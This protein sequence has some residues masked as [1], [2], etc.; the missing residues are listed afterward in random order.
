MSKAVNRVCVLLLG[1]GLFNSFRPKEKMKR[2]LI[3]S[4][5]IFLTLLALTF[6]TVG[7]TPAYAATF[8]VTTTSNNGAGSLR[9]AL[10]DAPSGST[11]T[12][13]ASLSGTTIYLAAPLDI[14]KKVKIDGSM[15]AT[16]I[17]ISGDSDGSGYG[18]VGVFTNVAGTLGDSVKLDSLNIIRGWV[19]YYGGGIYNTG[20]LSVNNC[21][22]DAN[23]AYEAGG[24]I[25]NS[26]MLMVTNSTFANN[27]VQAGGG[28][29]YNDGILTVTSSTFISNYTY[30]NSS[31]GG[32]YN[33]GTLSVTNSTL[34]GNSATNDGG[35]IY[36]TGTL[37]VTNSTL[38]TNHAS[39]VGG[40]LYVGGGTARVINSTINNNTSDFSAGGI[41]NAG[42]LVLI[43]STLSGNL[44]NLNG[45]AMF[46]SI[47][48]VANIY[49]STIAFNAADWDADINGGQAGGIYNSTS[50]TFNLINSLL[51]GNSVSG[52]PVY[53]DCYG[54]LSSYGGNLI[55]TASESP[56]GASC[57][58]NFV[59]GSW[60]NLNDLNLLGPL[61]N[62]GGPTATIALLPGNNAINHGNSVL[63]CVDDAYNPLVTDQRGVARMAGAWCDIGAYESST[64]YNL[65]LPLILR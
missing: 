49:N 9:Q 1:N 42:N 28:G 14:V 20:Y 8:T 65:F 43:N 35:G 58:I 41:Y 38:G 60:V 7:V 46:N 10:A 5:T 36:N 61:Q 27:F 22:F 12:F 37:T 48:G 56:S 52:A 24:A 21:R 44:A 30:Y 4:V 55:G 23:F 25:Y 39:S 45:G 53:D 19:F 26:G 59:G 31:G 11:I 51:A 18:D 16:K 17:T 2:S 64:I 15:L 57:T 33:S 29:I 63:G 40:G 32:I 62:N 3:H 50:A 54:T 6:S 13:D 34:S 47:F